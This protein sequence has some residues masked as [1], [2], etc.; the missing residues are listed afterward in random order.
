MF[1]SFA[2][3]Y[4]S[5]LKQRLQFAKGQTAKEATTMRHNLYMQDLFFYILSI[6]AKLHSKTTRYLKD[7]GYWLIQEKLHRQYT[8]H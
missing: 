4:I 6:Q 7:E 2:K 8:I 3:I 5:R 1:L